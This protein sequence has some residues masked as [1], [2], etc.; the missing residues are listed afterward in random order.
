[1]GEW[2]TIPDSA[3]TVFL[4]SLGKEWVEWSVFEDE[5]DWDFPGQRNIF[6]RIPAKSF[7]LFYQ[8]EVPGQANPAAE[9]IMMAVGETK[10]EAPY[11]TY[12][13]IKAVYHYGEATKIMSRWE[14][15]LDQFEQYYRIG[16]EH[17]DQASDNK[18][19]YTYLGYIQD[20]NDLLYEANHAVGKVI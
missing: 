16:L 10:R 13:H 15:V 8:T 4:S 1:M 5:F 14:S 19:Y 6:D 12:I 2:I 9:Q 7:M 17:I 18:V 3:P 20:Y 11:G